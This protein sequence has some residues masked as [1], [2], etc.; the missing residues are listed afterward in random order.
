[1]SAHNSN[2]PLELRPF[3][4][5]VWT[6]ERPQRF[7]GVE[8]GARMTVLALDGGLLLHS[9]IDVPPAALAPLGPPRW[10]VAPNKLHHL[11]LAP[12]I[13]AGAE[14]WCAPGLDAKRGDLTFAGVLDAPGEPFGPEVSV[15]PLS[16]IALTNEVVVLHRPSRTL[17]VTD[18]LYNFTP[19]DPW[20]TRAA[21]WALGG[22]PG[23]RTS[24]LEK[25]LMKRDRARREIDHLLEL[26]FDRLIM[27]H[28]EPLE[29]GGKA[30][31][32]NAFAWL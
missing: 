4:E 32:A 1:M 30:A 18:L 8:V 6:A 3:A 9:P 24:L 26:D 12:W 25:A 22:Y 7:A 20:T 14:A 5:G 11:Y 16:C 29:R 2:V 19:R 10:V 15:V 31:L 13:D 27:A 28:G 23:V 17:I 21:L